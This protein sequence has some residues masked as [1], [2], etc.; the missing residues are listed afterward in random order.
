MH[1]I[2]CLLIV[3]LSCLIASCSLI[4]T[5]YNNAPALTIFWLDGYFSFNQAQNLALKPSLQK[6][7]QWHRQTQLPEYIKQL[8]AIQTSL[9]RDNLSPNDVCDKLAAARLSIHT[10]QI[11]SIPIMIEMAPQL[12]DKQLARFQKKLAER[13]EKWKEEFWQET[14]QAQVDARLEK[15]EDFAEDMYGDLNDAQLTLLKQSIT[16]ANINPAISY[17]EILRRNE[18]ALSTLKQLQNSSL[19]AEEKSQL[20]KAGLARMQK[21]PNQAYQMYADALTKHTCESMAN[22]H[23]STTLKQKLH[24]KNWLQDYIVQLTALQN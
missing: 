6:L 23:A 16:Q 12:S 7:H 20:V 2:K 17:A 13:A 14:K 1:L 21:S 22:L 9:A 19:G 11:E 3:L 15:A 18:D 5:T 10:L 8:Q 24:A 4:K